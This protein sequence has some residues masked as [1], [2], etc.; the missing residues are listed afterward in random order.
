MN[1]EQKIKIAMVV[2]VVVLACAVIVT[3]T[4]MFGGS[5]AFSYADAEKYTAGETE[6][7]EEIRNLEINWTSGKV[8]IA[9]HAGNTV[10]IRESSERALSE[11]EQLRWW[12]DGDTLRI[13][14]AKSGFRLNMPQKVLTVTLP[15]GME[16][17][18]VSI[19]TTS[20]DIEIPA[21]KA[22]EMRLAAT[23][24]SMN[25]AA[26]TRTAVTESTSGNQKI[27]LEGKA[28]SVTASSTSG[29][30]SLE[31]DRTGSITARS[32]SGGIFA[33]A[34]ECDTL[35]ASATSG[36]ITLKPG[37]AGRIEAG[38]T[39]GSVTAVLS[40]NPG[41]TAEVSTTSGSFNSTIAL[42]RDGNVYTCG[43]GSGRVVIGTTSG[44]VRIEKETEK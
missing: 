25:A 14:L 37:K 38:A 2:C 9:Y 4:G 34:A 29:S 3:S 42:T 15:E 44:N 39:S 24:G 18:N 26:E 43:D 11:D 13:Q 31:A 16:A 41:F 23:S 20:G 27:R 10:Q 19:R 32:T 40:E 35:K 5:G 12:K 8:V 1:R 7:A 21:L 30:I 36:S 22:E 17:G 28:E 33:A 6:I